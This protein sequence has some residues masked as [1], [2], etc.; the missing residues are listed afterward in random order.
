MRNPCRNNE[1]LARTDCDNRVM[2]F[3]IHLPFQY[4]QSLIEFMA[5]VRIR[6]GIHTNHFEVCAAYTTQHLGAPRH[7]QRFG[8][9]EKI[10]FWHNF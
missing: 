4:Q 6:P 5:F 3:Q 1:H 9:G 7:L 8:A 10:N 2:N